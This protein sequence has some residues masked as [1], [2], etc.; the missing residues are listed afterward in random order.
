MIME[1]RRNKKIAWMVLGILVC[2]NT[3]A[4]A[5]VKSVSTDHNLEVVFFDVG[6]GDSIFIETSDG[7]QVLIDGGPG[8]AV[9]EKLGEEMAFYD[10]E[11]D[12]II[13]THPEHDHMFG[14]LEV[15]KRYEIKNILWTGIIRDTAEWKE[16]KRLIEEE[17]A[18][19]L[20]A[21]TGQKIVLSENIYLSILYPFESLEGQETKYTND[22]SIVAELIF[23]NVSFLFTGD[24]SKK[25]EKQLV[26]EY[27]DLESDILKI[28]HHGSKTSSCL[29]FLEVVS[30]EL[31]VISVGENR[32]GHPHPETLANLEKFGIQVL[33]TRNY[34]DIKIVS[35]GNSFNIK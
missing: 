23:N 5:V 17:G 22:T 26:D 33:T 16:W 13:L 29:E 27:I 21:E 32:W 14:L 25:I 15:L 1:N 2:I 31:V 8:L 24:I 18:N 11:I 7:F 35:N 3:V 34:G 9:L 20:I 28:A 12:L 6:Q 19:I 4:W 10:R 30:P